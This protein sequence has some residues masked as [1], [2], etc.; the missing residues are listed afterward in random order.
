ME[1]SCKWVAWYW[2]IP[3]GWYSSD[4]YRSNTKE[5]LRSRD[6]S[7]QI[8][9]QRIWF[10][11]FSGKR[12]W[13]SDLVRVGWHG[14]IIH[15]LTELTEV[16]HV[17]Q[18]FDS[19]GSRNDTINVGKFLGK[20][21]ERKTV[22]WC[23]V[24]LEARGADFSYSS[25]SQNN[26]RD[27]KLIFN[28]LRLFCTQTH[29]NHNSVSHSISLYVGRRTIGTATNYFSLLLFYFHFENLYQWRVSWEIY[30]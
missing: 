15:I 20:L 6:E 23:H 4:L 26:S 30:L 2:V 9:T 14:G 19:C 24:W 17:I 22:F 18:W 5:C 7:F 29:T 27:I 10:R 16:W 28:C 13:R 11:N 8:S 1:M 12:E 21:T 3:P 25:I